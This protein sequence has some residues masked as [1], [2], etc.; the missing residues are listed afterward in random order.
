MSAQ[1]KLLIG[2]IAITAFIVGIALNTSRVSDEIDSKALL[3]AK[4]TADSG[5]R[6]VDDE[7]GKLTL[8]N[9]WASWCAPCREEMPIFEMMYRGAKSAGFQII[10]V[11]IDSPEKAQPMLD[12]M[13]IT[14]PILYA[15]QTGMEI[16]ELSGNPAGLMPYSLLLDK[17][18]KV[19]EQVLGKID[20]RQIADWLRESLEV[21]MTPSADPE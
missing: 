5:P 15:E 19:L 1:N 11:A 14:Y 12:S 7:L 20:E 13:G 21:N 10:G 6:T 3:S 4:L 2:F 9:F 16:M 17:N 18:G 8:V